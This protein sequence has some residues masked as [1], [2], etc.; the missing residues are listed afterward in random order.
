MGSGRC[1]G[2]GFGIQMQGAGTAAGLSS[3]CEFRASLLRGSSNLLFCQ[4]L[5]AS[6]RTGRVI[7]EAQVGIGRGRSTCALLPLEEVFPG[8]PGRTDCRH[9][10]LPVRA[11]T[12]WFCMP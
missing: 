7:I 8:S 12:C 4:G 1:Q 9:G 5:W 3:A 2:S 10:P 11:S 6:Y